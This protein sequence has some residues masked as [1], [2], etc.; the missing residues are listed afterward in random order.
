MS[1]A[2]LIAGRFAI[3]DPQQALLGRGGMGEVYLA[4]DMI[5]GQQVAVKALQSNVANWHPDLVARFVQEGEALRR[6][7]HPNIVKMVAAV[8]EE[9]QHYLAMEYVSGG[10]LRGLLNR[11][12]LLP[13]PR[14][15]EIALEVADALARAHHLRILHRDLKP[16]N[17]LLAED[18]TPR[19]TDFGIAYLEDAATRLTESGM[20]LGTFEYLAPEI[21]AGETADVRAD[22]WGLG[23]MLFE[24]VAGRRPFRGTTTAELI[25]NILADPVPDLSGLR[26]DIPVGLVDLIGRMLAKE[27]SKR[28]PSARLVAAALEG[29]LANWEVV[30]TGGRPQA[31]PTLAPAEDTVLFPATPVSRHNLPME[32]TPFIGREAEV[33]AL[34]ELLEEAS[35]RLVTILGPGGIGKTRLAL[36]VA[37]AQLEQT[38]LFRQGVFFV[39]LAP[40]QSAGQIPAAIAKAVDFVFR[41]GMEEQQQLV[42]YLQSKGMLLVLDNFEHLLEGAAVVGDLLQL[43]GIKIVVTSRERLQLPGEQLFPLAGLEVPDADMGDDVSRYAAVRLFLQQARRARPTFQ[44]APLER[45]AVIHI[46]RQLQ[47]MPLAIVL[48]AAWV[49]M[50]TPVEIAAEIEQSLDFLATD[51][52]DLPERQ[53]SLRAIFDYAWHSL[54]AREQAIFGQLSVFRGGFT[55][56]AA[57]VVTGASLRELMALVNK[58]LLYRAANGRYELHELVRQYATEKLEQLPGENEAVRERACA[59]YATLTEKWTADLHGPREAQA[60]AEMEADSENCRLAWQWAVGL[61][62][63]ERLRQMVDGLSEYYLRVGL[64]REGVAV[65]H[66]AATSLREV[67]TIEARHLLARMWAWHSF[68]VADDF[69]QR[70]EVKQRLQQA[71]A[72]LDELTLQGIDT[73]RERAIVLGRMASMALID[74]YYDYEQALDWQRE[75]LA[76]Q[77]TIG[78]ERGIGKALMLLGLIEARLGHP[79]EGQVLLE[80]SLIRLQQVGARNAMG[81]ALF[82]LASLALSKGL[83]ETAEQYTRQSLA[84]WQETKDRPGTVGSL[85]LLGFIRLVLGDFEEACSLSE[86]ALRQS[87]ELGSPNRILEDYLTLGEVALLSGDY[88]EA[89]TM[90]EEGLVRAQEFNSQW[91]VSAGRRLQSHLAWLNGDVIEAKRLA[92]EAETMV[93]VPGEERELSLILATLAWLHQ[94]EG[95]LSAAWKYGCEALQLALELKFFVPLLSALVAAAPILADSNEPEQAIEAYALAGRYPLVVKSPFFEAIAGRRI[96]AAAA[97]LPAEDVAA[98]HE[99]GR[100]GELWQVAAAVLERLSAAQAVAVDGP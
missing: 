94:A 78:D 56:E 100:N 47:G 41:P 99:R 11:P 26:P 3:T 9:G 51:R 73:R 59:Y 95:D 38:A 67:A 71:V 28:M 65:C 84:I 61:S 77:R 54:G 13:L 37:A 74:G 7:N 82:M 53:R 29:L 4:T 85:S 57:E 14:V 70:E 66:S 69:G 55:R 19:L 52:R 31:T 25:S 50:L 89:W 43:P 83:P 27:R 60:L 80:E 90:V 75:S 22:I 21:Y 91:A 63:V 10:S 39:P 72:L 20:L 1:N 88:Q 76:L 34:T 33:A 24:M 64:L 79:D 93:R 44:L 87:I 2:R 92:L 42:Q 97:T 17:V 12:E 23:V 5:T 49:E 15:L 86:D 45:V 48:A 62:E 36:A 30:E 81:D 68:F 98:A 32:A 35:V 46:C 96:Q 8:E 6:L 16:G 40:L 58:S 18:G